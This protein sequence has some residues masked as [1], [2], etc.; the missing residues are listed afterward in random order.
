MLPYM[1]NEHLR[2]LCVC[3]SSQHVCMCVFVCTHVNLISAAS[4]SG[5]QISDEAQ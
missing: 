2:P 1:V 3:T 4:Q 5:V